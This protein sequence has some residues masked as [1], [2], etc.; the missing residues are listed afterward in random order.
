M[1]LLLG[2][3]VYNDFM[4]RLSKDLSFIFILFILLS[5]SLYFSICAFLMLS[6]RVVIIL[7]KDFG[8]FIKGTAKTKMISLKGI[9]DLGVFGSLY[10]LG[11]RG[12]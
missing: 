4:S 2:I 12:W 7:T 6:K 1:H 9:P 3:W 8:V 10:I 5:K 11:I